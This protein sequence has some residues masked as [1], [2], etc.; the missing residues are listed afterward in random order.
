ML[1]GLYT[2]GSAMS[3]NARRIDVVSNNLANV[4][5][6][7]FKKDEALSESFEEV[8][9]MKRGGTS[10]NYNYSN[11]GFTASEYDG[12]FLLNAPKGFIKMDGKTELNYSHSAEV[13]VD[14][15]GYLSTF[16]RDGNKSLYPTKGHRVYGQNGYIQ[17]GD[18]QVSFDDS[19]NVLVDGEIVDNIVYKPAANV[20]GTMGHGVRIERTETLFEQGQLERTDYEFDL[21]IDG[22][23]F[24]EVETTFGTAYTR[25][26]RFKIDQFNE[27]VTTEGFTVT[28]LNGP[29]IIDG[30]NFQVNQFG[31]VI[32]D[33]ETVDKLQLHNITNTFDLEKVGSGY[34]V[35]EEGFDLA[36][37]EF[38]AAVRQ[39][40]IEKSNANNLEEMITLMELYRT[41]ESNQ[42]MV[43]AY[44]ST[45]DKAV[46]QI[47]RL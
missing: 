28:G 8:L 44:D 38:D 22:K 30:D 1:R 23:G 14:D 36:E 13:R 2:A 9:V 41:Y 42:R 32:V 26:G 11:D 43:T 35:Y 46:N 3:V 7:A 16:Y 6:I 39:G 12:K 47:G 34:F 24:F 19:G 20:I 5:T 17:V 29:I 4:D 31:E 18:G 37:D 40:Y 33:G 15:E 27:L 10:K 25:D 45:L 21:A